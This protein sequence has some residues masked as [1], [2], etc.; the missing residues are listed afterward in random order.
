MHYQEIAPI[1]S[2]REYVRF[3][4]VL[5]DFTINSEVHNFK[6]I[7]DG[8]PALIFQDKPSLFYGEDNIIT[9]QLYIYGQ[10]TKFTN[11][12]VAEPFR[13][14]GA[15]LEPTA[16]KSIF[17]IDASEFNNQNI[18]LNDI[19][20]ESIL[21]QLVNAYTVKD[22]IDILSN[23]LLLKL[24]TADRI[25]TKAEFAS[26]LLQNG[27]TVK[28]VQ[29][30]MNLSERTLE[31]MI[32]QHIG[33]SPKSFSRINRFQSSLK[34]I[35]NLDFKSL[36]EISYENDYFDQSHFIRDFRDLTGSKPTDFLV[37]A[38]EQLINFPKWKNNLD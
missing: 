14:I 9:P 22:K 25:N 27:A 28:Q 12:R 26:K 36:T 31:R 1:E 16:L 5:E 19:A 29:L 8:L 38:E 2:L 17:K 18:S 35:R 10:F 20:R 37:K 3:F 15:Y 33:M 30:E 34:I 24:N 13:I 7:P 32:K 21:E 23:F 4:W 6:I 11:Q